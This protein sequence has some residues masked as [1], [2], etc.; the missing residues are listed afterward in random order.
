MCELFFLQMDVDF[1]INP[2]KEMS[3]CP[4][5]VRISVWLLIY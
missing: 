5:M 2:D 4:S 1:R 3:L